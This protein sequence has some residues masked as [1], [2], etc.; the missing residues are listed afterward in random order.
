[1]KYFIPGLIVGIVLLPAAVFLYI[2]LGY[3]PI[4]TAAPPLPFEQRLAA[5]ALQAR[6]EKEAPKESPVPPTEPNLLAGAETYRQQCAVCHGTASGPETA[7][8]KGMFP[9]PPQLFQGE[10]VTDD[11]VGY[12]FWKAANGIR[13]SGMPSFRGALTDEQ[14]WQVSQ[15]LANADKLPQS[16]KDLLARPLSPP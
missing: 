5:M 15:L 2:W 13:L 1:M 9:P 6:L 3:M 11:P 14:L 16:V 4:G 12:T 8:G 7:I 10:G